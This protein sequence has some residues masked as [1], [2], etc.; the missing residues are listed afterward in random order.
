MAKIA[1]LLF[2]ALLAAG[3]ATPTQTITV[4][5]SDPRPSVPVQSVAVASKTPSGG[6]LLAHLFASAANTPSG[7]EAAQANLK[8]CA[9]AIGAN[10][11]VVDYWN[12]S[13]LG[14][15]VDTLRIGGDAFFLPPESK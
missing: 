4:R 6:V 5:V 2:V 9:A 13:T 12:I 14:G 3:C 15:E 10:V 7:A 1:P 8:E 11:L